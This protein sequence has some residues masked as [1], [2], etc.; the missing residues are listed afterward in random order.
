MPHGDDGL[1]I[2]GQSAALT[3]ALPRP[4]RVRRIR[5]AWV[6]VGV[7]LALFGLSAVL[8]GVPMTRDQIFLWLLLGLLAFSLSDLRTW[9]RGVVVDWIPVFGVLFAYDFLRGFAD[10]LAKS[11]H[12]WP[13]LRADEWLFG[14]TVPTVILQRRFFAIEDPQWYDYAAWLIYMS[15]FF[16]ALG[17]GAV[18]WKVA[19]PR[20]RQFIAMF[21][22]LT[23]AGF[24]T[25]VVLPAVPP[26]LASRNGD[27]EP[28]TRLILA[29]WDHLGVGPAT[30]VFSGGNRYANDVAALPSLHGAYP[31]LL[32]L[33]FWGVSRPWARAGLVAYTLLMCLTLVYAAEHYVVDVLMGWC[34]AAV[35]FAAARA[36][37]R[38]RSPLPS[39]VQ[40]VPRVL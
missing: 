35:V 12:V 11:A 29:M 7:Y 28:T 37:I 4:L 8:F 36:I 40:P 30:A 14:G 34:Y 32:L 1:R 16:V 18:L 22:A 9:L 21:I 31:A 27:L 5:S 19:Y 24:A 20:F 23:L 13:Q 38:R 26:W 25:Y 15:H 2:S 6:A 33:F 3:G 17:V 10:E 39:V